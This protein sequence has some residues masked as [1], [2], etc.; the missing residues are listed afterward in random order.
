M[1]L[2]TNERELVAVMKRYFATKIEAET[3]KAR[4]ETARQMTDE[5][6]AVFYDPRRNLIHAS[7]ILHWH[8]LKREMASLI[9]QAETLGRAAFAADRHD[10]PDED[11]TED[12]NA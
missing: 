7:D 8:R 9:G 10:R 5:T 3:M 4:L 12:T 11:S 2:Y 6:V 1:D